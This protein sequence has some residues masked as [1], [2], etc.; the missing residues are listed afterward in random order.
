[1]PIHTHIGV[2]SFGDFSSKV[3]SDWAGFWCAVRLYY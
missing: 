2:V 3:G 1:M